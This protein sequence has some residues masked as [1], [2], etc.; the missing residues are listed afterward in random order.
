MGPVSSVVSIGVGQCGVQVLDAA[1][2]AIST[3]GGA[4]QC[5]GGET[6]WT[7]QKLPRRGARG[8]A[9]AA[10]GGVFFRDDGETARAVLIDM[11][12]KVVAGTVS[13][14]ARN[15]D[16]GWRYDPDSCLVRD[17]G[18]CGNN[19]AYGHSVLGPQNGEGIAESVRRE[20]EKCDMLGGFLLTQSAAGGT[21]SGVGSY[22][23]SLVRDLY[24]SSSV[25]THCVLPYSSGE[26]SVQAYNT[27]LTLAATLPDVD[28]AI[29][30][31]NQHLMDVCTKAMRISRPSV[32][33]VNG[34]AAKEIASVVLPVA[35]G[36]LPGTKSTRL[37][38]GLCGHL[39]PHPR[40]KL[41]TIRSAPHMPDA[42]I[43]FTTYSWNSILRTLD[44]SMRAPT[45]APGTTSCE[46]QSEPL[47][48]PRTMAV[49]SA[50]LLVLRGRESSVAAAK[51]KG[52]PA[53]P[54]PSNSSSSTPPQAVSFGE[55]GSS[56]LTFADSKA[57]VPWSLAPLA[58]E[59]AQAPF[60]MHEMSASMLANSSLP[61][62]HV[63]E[64]LSCSYRMLNAGAYVHNYQQHGM[65]RCEWDEA[66]ATAEEV[67]HAY[68]GSR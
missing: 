68:R 61:V 38:H 35:G 65:D 39:C 63:Q 64:A 29:L 62:S 55:E 23:A 15:A 28:G 57:Y 42:S 5:S 48:H 36:S 49:S 59:H 52:R 13:R 44:A 11:E 67:V 47:L 4:A 32:W 31:P 7:R 58:V 54:R 6:G 9:S 33:D 46:G 10:P 26:V 51:F 25:V 16:G 53:P 37:L 45:T 8:R 56:P 18:G 40:M 1:L 30:V 41:L 22:T 27:M 50:S 21:G 66:I 14:R 24:P 60:G 3:R 17:G 2:D 20:A 19:W 12:A 43:D 34:V